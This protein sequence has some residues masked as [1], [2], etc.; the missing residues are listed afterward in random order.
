MPR[1]GI[2]KSYVQCMLNYIGKCPAFFPELPDY[3]TFSTVCMRVPVAPLPSLHLVLFLSV[4]SHYLF[5]Y[6]CH[7][8]RQ[9]VVF[10]CG[11]SF[12]FPKDKKM[13]SIFLWT[14][15]SPMYVLWWDVCLNELPIVLLGYVFPY[16]HESWEF[17]I[18][19][20]HKSFIRYVICKYFLPVCDIFY[21]LNGVCQKA[22]F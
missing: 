4:S 7:S 6:I 20:R 3:F 8:N 19:S 21:S 17:F 16:F 14:Y 22:G 13:L 9:V 15:L 12:H 10:C 2:A 11:F 5:Y 1:S 18:Y